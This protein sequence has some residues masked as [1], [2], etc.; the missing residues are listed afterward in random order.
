[1]RILF[2][3]CLALAQLL[4]PMGARANP[5]PAE[6]IA[7]AKPGG[8]FELTCR[9][10]RDML[11]LP[12]PAPIADVQIRYMPGG[13][14]AV[15]FDRA[16][17]QQW[18]HPRTFIA[19]STGSLVNLAQ[20]KFGPHAPGDVRW[21]ATLGVEYGA[22]AVRRNSRIGTLRELRDHLARN[23][24]SAVFGAGGT[25]GSQDW[26]KAALLVRAAGADHRA[27][28]F[29]A[30]EG[31]G[32]A[33]DALKG[34]H[35]EVFCGDMLEVAE[36]VATGEVRLLAV[37]APQRLSG[38]MAN[39][40]TAREQGIDVV[41]ST[42]RGVYMGP[43]VPDRDYTEWARTLRHVMQQPAFE[44]LL[45]GH[46]LQPH[47]LVGPEVHPYVEQ[48]VMQLRELARGLNLRVR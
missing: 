8:G 26:I 13:I 45:R 47:P 25:V 16:V 5:V 9:L 42:V 39:V 7:P 10:L 12:L 1:M 3:L 29:V 30:F 15:A 46:G 31:G 48:Q 19:F 14:G 18:N 35:V 36:A 17:T 44:R 6:C 4:V 37:L 20:G 40:P 38:P 28:R 2:T 23:P 33:L 32:Q 43:G 22:V 34:G 24:A 21:L 41:W 11:R 27:M